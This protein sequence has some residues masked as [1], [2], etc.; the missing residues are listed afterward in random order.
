MKRVFAFGCSYTAYSY[1]TWADLLHL[2][3]DHVENWGLPGIGNRAI[4]ER[5]AECHAKNKFTKDDIVIVQWSSHLRNDWYSTSSNTDRFAGWRTYGSIF[6]YHNAKLYDKE[7][8]DTFFFEP[9]YVM[10]TLNSIVATQSL[11]KFTGCVWYM[12]SIGDVRE[13]GNDLRQ[14]DNYGEL[15]NDAVSAGKQGKKAAWRLAKE[16]EVYDDTIWSDHK[17]HWLMPFELFCQTCPEHTFGYMDVDDEV[18]LDLHPTPRQHI[19]WIKQEL[20]DKI[21]ISDSSIAGGLELAEHVE[22][23]QQKFKSNKISFDYSVRKKDKFPQ[24]VQKLMWPGKPY[25]F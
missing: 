18:F 8:I 12:T 7:W 11:L 1:P 14:N 10:H 16:L 4:A 3:F 17:D 22:K 5:I 23:M 20:K 13:L 2:D 24:S 19:L 21:G 9:A 6:N 25:G 15:T